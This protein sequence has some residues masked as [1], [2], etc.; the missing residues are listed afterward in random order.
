MA[1]HRPGA[2]SWHGLN[3]FCF[4]N[5][6]THRAHHHKT[7]PPPPCFPALHK[8]PH[9]CTN[10][11]N[12]PHPHTTSPLH[13]QTWAIRVVCVQFRVPE[14]FWPFSAVPCQASGRL[15]CCASWV[16]H[17]HGHFHGS[18]RLAACSCWSL[19]SVHEGRICSVGSF[20]FRLRTGFLLNLAQP[21]R[22]S[23]LFCLRTHRVVVEFGTVCQLYDVALKCRCLAGSMGLLVFV[24]YPQG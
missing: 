1:G 14:L 11:A 6:Y 15:S 2:L 20:Q 7:S 22:S 9:T 12:C 19:C 3:L 18:A 17:L 13:S 5:P 23:F 16:S 24:S 4:L 10:L 8:H 21:V